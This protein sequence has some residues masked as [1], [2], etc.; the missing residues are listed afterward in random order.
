[1]HAGLDELLNLRD[2][3]PVSDTVRAHVG[4]CARCTAAIA[5]T[6]VLRERLQSLPAV[7]AAATDGWLAVEERLAATTARRR[8]AAAFG[9]LAAAASVAAL[10]L[11]AALRW[12]EA[13]VRPSSASSASSAGPAPVAV[14]ELRS[15]SQ[16]L[17]AMLAAL[18]A[19]P[20]VARAGTAVPIESLEAQ[21]QWLDHQILLAD[22]GEPSPATVRLWNDRVEVMS[23]LVQLR[24]VEAQALFP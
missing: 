9:S 7:P 21:V 2:G 16:A 24:Y 1:M 15:R 3:E 18:P 22:A 13:P 5:H 10:A 19:R 14:D 11:F 17:E 6:R 20:A 4:H 23:S 8:R 12:H